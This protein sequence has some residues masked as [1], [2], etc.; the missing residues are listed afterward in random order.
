MKG[1]HPA[2]KHFR[3][4]GDVGD[5]SEENLVRVETMNFKTKTYSMGIP[6]SLIFLA[7]PPD[8]NKRTPAACS[9]FA[10]SMRSVLSYTDRRANY[11]RL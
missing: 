7:V 5:I 9:P 8:P 11:R 2:A 6:A 3:S 1:L 10:K 4:L